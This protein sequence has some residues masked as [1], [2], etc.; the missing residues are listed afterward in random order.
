M[1]KKSVSNGAR[2]Y[3][4]R[5]KITKKNVVENDCALTILIVFNKDCKMIKAV[6]CLNN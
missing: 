2:R 5:P 1:V 6:S 3:Q 4:R